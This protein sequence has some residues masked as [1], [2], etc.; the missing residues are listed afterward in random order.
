[1]ENAA[2]SLG[3]LAARGL[4]VTYGHD[5]QLLVPPDMVHSNAFSPAPLDLLEAESE[6]GVG[7]LLE[8]SLERV[9]GDRP[10]V[11]MVTGPPCRSSDP[12][13]LPT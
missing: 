5:V 1:M 10:V 8:Q 9:L 7:Y 4:A 6:G 13:T 12:R 2:R 11:A 3:A